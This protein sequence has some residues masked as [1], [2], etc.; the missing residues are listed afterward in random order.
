MSI[1]ILKNDSE[2]TKDKFPYQI[3]FSRGKYK[4]SIV[5]NGMCDI[6][7]IIESYEKFLLDIADKEDK[8]INEV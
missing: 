2:K 4:H 1:E 5:A 3:L 6:N 7:L 8:E